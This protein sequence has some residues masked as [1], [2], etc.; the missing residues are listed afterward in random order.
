MNDIYNTLAIIIGSYSLSL[1]FFLC[2]G[3]AL[4]LEPA[5]ADDFPII[6]GCVLQQAQRI[7]A[8]LKWTLLWT[9]QGQVSQTQRGTAARQML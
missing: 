6:V 8:F 5:F 3:F 1:S 7:N 2:C 9:E 4:L